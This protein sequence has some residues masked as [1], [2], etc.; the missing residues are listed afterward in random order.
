MV[1][2]VGFEGSQHAV[3]TTNIDDS[4][5]RTDARVDVST[6]PRVDAGPSEQRDGQGVEQA[7]GKALV[8]ASAEGRWDVVIQLARELELRRAARE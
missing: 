4:G 6:Q 1:A 5:S 2:R 8:E 3:I 7:L